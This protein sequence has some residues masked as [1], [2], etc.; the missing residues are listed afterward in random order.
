MNT[1][2]A[3]A[4]IKKDSDALAKKEQESKTLTA[5]LGKIP[6]VDPD[7]IPAAVNALIEA[8]Y[9]YLSDRYLVESDGKRRSPGI[10]SARQSI[11][12]LRDQLTAGQNQV[13]VLLPN[14]ASALA[15]GYKA[16]I[17]KLKTV[18]SKSG[19]SLSVE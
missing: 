5:L 1:R 19:M 11:Q 9:H 10:A 14:A 18:F 16:P 4:L 3:D 7:V 8:A 6:N 17:G 15:F 12:T 13:A 2:E